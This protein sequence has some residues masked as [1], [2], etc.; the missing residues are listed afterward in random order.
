MRYLFIDFSYLKFC[1]LFMILLNNYFW[2]KYI[3][4]KCK[5]VIKLFFSIKKFN[6]QNCKK[7]VEKFGNALY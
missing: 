7:Y 4:Y 6:I 1:A 3:L 2:K 5:F